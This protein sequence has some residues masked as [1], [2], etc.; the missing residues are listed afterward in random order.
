MVKD[1][2][3]LKKGRTKRKTDSE[4]NLTLIVESVARK[5]TLKNDVGKAPVRIASLNVLGV[6]IHLI[7]I[8]TRKYKNRNI[9]QHGLAPSPHPRRTIQKTSFATTP[10]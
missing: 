10:I 5:L 4:E 9:T 3:K 1:C 8:Q 2:E 6:T 7:T